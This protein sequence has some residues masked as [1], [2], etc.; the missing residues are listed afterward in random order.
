MTA[1]PK[2]PPLLPLVVVA[3]PGADPALARGLALRLGV[4]LAGETEGSEG[5]RAEIELWLTGERLELRQPGQ[6]TGP[7]YADFASAGFERRRR[8]AGRRSE[9]LAR[10]VGLGKGPPPY[11]LDATAGLG[12]DSV[13]LAS[14]GC[15]VTAVER[16][17][18]VAALLQDG[19]LRAESVP[20]LRPVVTGRQRL[21]VADAR[22]VLAGCG[23]DAPDVVLLD[24]MYPLERRTA[25]AR[26]E[27]AV[28]RRLVGGDED[29]D[30]LLERALDVARRRVV[31]KRPARAPRMAGRPPDVQL[32][33]ASTRLDVY[34]RRG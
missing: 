34:L 24:P 19:L 5:P 30:E 4:P 12:R 17:V 2:A 10:A 33:G 7:V 1:A 3:R 27:L 9:A 13:L 25:L 22:D 28:L 18:V 11:V 16:Q 29:A 32:A 23:A 31:V 8:L 21:I 26:K 20:A 6:R 14:V 15:R